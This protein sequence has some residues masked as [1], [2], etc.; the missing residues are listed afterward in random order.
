MISAIQENLR[1]G[2]MS[3]NMLQ[4]TAREIN[5]E[6]CIVSEPPPRV[7]SRTGWYVSPDSTTAIILDPLLDSTFTWIRYGLR[8]GEDG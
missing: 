2:Y 5:S 7:A 3:L 6:I 8:L 4:Q 1:G